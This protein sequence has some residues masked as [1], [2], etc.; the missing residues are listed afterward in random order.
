MNKTEEAERKLFSFSLFKLKRYLFWIVYAGK[1]KCR[2]KALYSTAKT[3]VQ[4][5]D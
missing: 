2:L 3:L 1:S 5:T 4:S